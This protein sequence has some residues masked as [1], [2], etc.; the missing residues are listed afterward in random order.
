MKDLKAACF[1]K[2]G[3]APATYPKHFILFHPHHQLQT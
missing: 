2:V 1:K 3:S